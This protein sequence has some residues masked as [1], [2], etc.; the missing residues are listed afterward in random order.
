M[1]QFE[2]VHYQKVL[3]CLRFFAAIAEM[4]GNPIEG[5]LKRAGEVNLAGSLLFFLACDRDFILLGKLIMSTHAL[6]HAGSCCLE[7]IIQKFDERLVRVL[8]SASASN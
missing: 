3:C 1:V 7:K 6:S 4:P 2:L 8:E 5:L